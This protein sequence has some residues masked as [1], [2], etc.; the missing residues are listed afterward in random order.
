MSRIDFVLACASNDI[1]THAEAII[2]V[3]GGFPAA[4]QAIIDGMT[5]AD[6][7]FEAEIRWRGAT[8]IDRTNPLIIN[9]AASIFMDEW[10]LD[11]LFGVAWPAP[12]ASWPEGQLHP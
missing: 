12:L 11:L 2:A 8:V 6:E 4:F 5:H 1:L 10:S 7:K 3:D 9:M